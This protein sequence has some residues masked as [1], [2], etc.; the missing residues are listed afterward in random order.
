M[1]KLV[2]E[3][4]A[5][6]HCHADIL[7]LLVCKCMNDSNA[8]PQKCENGTQLSSASTA[9]HK[10]RHN[11]HQD[12]CLP[13]LSVSGSMNW[14]MMSSGGKVQSDTVNREQEDDRVKEGI[15]ERMRR[16]RAAK[17]REALGMTEAQLRCFWFL[18]GS[19]RVVRRGGSV[20]IS[21]L[22]IQACWDEILTKA[23]CDPY[24]VGFNDKASAGL[25]LLLSES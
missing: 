10:K 8:K 6:L 13:S 4:L 11:V 25:S 24:T 14:L 16:R 12:T 20:V 23:Y 18:V 15:R 3:E 5:T 17:E 22:I 1:S 7:A 21:F 2:A 19:W 9:I